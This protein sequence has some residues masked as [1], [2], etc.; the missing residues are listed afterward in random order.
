LTAKLEIGGPMASLYVLGNPDHYTGHVFVPFY[1]RSYIK[2]VLSASEDLDSKGIPDL[3][4]EQDKV[5]INKSR[6]QFIGV[7][8][9]DDYVHR[10]L[11][12]EAVPLYDWV[13]LA[14][15]GTKQKTKKK[16]IGDAVDD[17]EFDESDDELN[18][19][20]EI[21]FHKV[22]DEDV[23]DARHQS[24]DRRAVDA[25]EDDCKTE[26]PHVKSKE[27]CVDT[28]DPSIDVYNLPLSE[29]IDDD[30]GY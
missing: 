20:P 13:R 3:D 26:E 12:Y 22:D 15:K 5:V 4:N 21:P 17:P 9:V 10:P 24:S 18:I 28:R 11:I 1:W 30:L 2:M 27:F 23:I 14:K 29:F 16:Q 8:K 7:S 6:G 19:R 25:E